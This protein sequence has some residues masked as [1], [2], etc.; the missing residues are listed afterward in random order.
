MGT[1]GK[2]ARLVKYSLKGVTKEFDKDTLPWIDKATDAE[3]DEFVAKN[4]FSSFPYDMKEK[5]N[6]WRKNG[7]VIFEKAIAKE[8]ID[9]FVKDFEN[10]QENN[11]NFEHPY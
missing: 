7:Y 11:E 3:V 4:D 2:L 1:F 9:A 6:F 8:W 10:F 5:L